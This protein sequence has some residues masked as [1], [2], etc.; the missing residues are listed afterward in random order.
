[1][2]GCPSASQVPGCRAVK[3]RVWLVLGL[4]PNR[5]DYRIMKTQD[6]WPALYALFLVANR[7]S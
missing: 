2:S 6:D 3:N 1:M 7:L 5:L 4:D